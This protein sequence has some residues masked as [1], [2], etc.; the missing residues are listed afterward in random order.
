M[1]VDADAVVAA[2]GA[3]GLDGRLD[4][5]VKACFARAREGAVEMVWRI[6]W[7]GDQWDAKSV[8]LGELAYAQ[9]RAGATGPDGGYRRELSPMLSPGDALALLVAHLHVAGG[10]AEADALAAA[11]KVT[12]FELAQ[13]LDEYELVRPGKSGAGSGQPA[14]T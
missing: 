7:G 10:M 1:T 3:G 11:G 5:I 8:T 4:D 2:V 12:A 13:A 9:R 14:T 6:D